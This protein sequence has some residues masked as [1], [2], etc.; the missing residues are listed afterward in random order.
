MSKYDSL[1]AKWGQQQ[2]Q[3]PKFQDPIEPESLMTKWTGDA[4]VI[5]HVP[6]PVV[7]S[8]C[9][10]DPNLTLE[11]LYERAVQVSSDINE[12]VAKLRELS[13]QCDHVTEFGGR[14]GISSVGLLAGQPKRFVTYDISEDPMVQRLADLSGETDFE[15]RPGGS[16]EVEIEETDLLFIDT[17]H[18]AKQL[19]SEL[20][21]HAHMVRR[22]IALH[23]TKIYGEH[24]DDGGPGLLPSMRRFMTENP[25]WSV[26]YDVSNN[27]GFTVLSCD[28]RDKPKLPGV[29]EMGSNF[30]KAVAGHVADGMSNVDNDVLKQRLEV[31]S[32]CPQRNGERCARC[33]CGIVA[34]AKM[35]TQFCPI[36]KW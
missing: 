4:V 20:H 32:T 28:P 17:F 35:K 10:G 31:C 8:C 27:N 5:G 16:L 34:K 12:H 1:M 30:A 26:I 36:G 7:E 15:F 24:G 2:E 3:L 22:F 25:I 14:H 11:K 29:L 19:D 9:G 13:E 33:G 21:R 18:N 6:P 23:D